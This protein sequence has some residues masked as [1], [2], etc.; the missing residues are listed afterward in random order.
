MTNFINFLTGREN[1]A[2]IDEAFNTDP[3]EI[4]FGKKN[5]GDIF[6]TFIDEEDKEYR[7]QFYTPA[8]LGKNVRQVFIGQKRG[9]T[10]PDAISRFKNP[11][12]VISTMIEAT[13]QFLL[14]PIGKGIDGF[15]INF[16]KK[17]LERGLT[18]LPKIIRQS[19]LKA[20]L[21][22]M[23]L[24]YSPDPSRGY[25]W[26]IRKGSDPAAVFDGPKMK[27]IT[28]D[29]PD[30]V[31]D[32]PSAQDIRDAALQGDMDD[33]SQAINRTTMTTKVSAKRG[34]YTGVD[35]DRMGVVINIL[36]NGTTPII[37][38]QSEDIAKLINSKDYALQVNIAIRQG[39]Q[40]FTD[41]RVIAQRQS[42]RFG[43]EFRILNNVDDR[44]IA[45]MVLLKKPGLK[46]PTD[47]KDVAGS[48]TQT[49]EWKLTTAG[50]KG[51]Q[52][53]LLWTNTAGRSTITADIA[54]HASEPGVYIGGIMNEK[55]M[56][57]QTP[58]SVARVLR[59]PQIPLHLLNEFTRLS[60][61]FWKEN[62]PKKNDTSVLPKEGTLRDAADHIARM[63][64]IV[65]TYAP[66]QVGMFS[67]EK[68]TR[69]ASG[70]Y[71]T[72][73]G[74]NIQIHF[75][76]ID[77]QGYM[78][79]AVTGDIGP[80][81]NLSLTGT[82]KGAAME[83][84]QAIAITVDR[85]FD[86]E[87]TVNS[88]PI[89]GAPYVI[90]G[91]SGSKGYSY[92]DCGSFT[93]KI[94]DALIN[95][96]KIG[97]AW[98]LDLQ[99]EF[100]R[101][102][103]PIRLNWYNKETLTVQMKDGSMIFG[104]IKTNANQK[105][106][107][108]TANIKRPANAKFFGEDVN[109]FSVSWKFS[110][111][112]GGNLWGAELTSNVTYY[113]DK[114]KASINTMLV[115]NGKVMNAARSYEVDLT[116]AS[117][118]HAIDETSQRLGDAERQVRLLDDEQYN[119]NGL[120]LNDV[121]VDSYGE[122]RFQDKALHQS[123]NRNVIINL[124]S[125]PQ[126]QSGKTGVDLAT[127]IAQ[128]DK[129]APKTSNVYWNFYAARDGQS[130]NVGWSITFRRNSRVGAMQQYAGEIRRANE[131]LGDLYHRAIAAGY[132][133]DK[134][135]LMTLQRAQSGDEMSERNGD[136]AYSEYEQ[137]IGGDMQIRIK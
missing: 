128:A 106:A 16:S 38:F 66:Q 75:M 52:P 78:V 18:L 29:D 100:P 62:D 120:Y 27:G 5:A 118:Q 71:R 1:K 39:E 41:T 127:F 53:M 61:S 129:E 47:T 13:K 3:Y 17:A 35:V 134:P 117:I 88:V 68:L 43:F 49:S 34:T 4:T 112:R 119:P 82:T 124:L 74:M 32:A 2:Q 50:P 79:V 98:E 136:G 22:V 90:N 104:D 10:Y 125:R 92:V 93:V 21:N 7:I 12:R 107:V 14:T 64:G 33:L 111:P 25:V 20:K 72:S 91:I 101:T 87:I 122:V 131:Y 123:A 105:D 115:Q 114:K 57:G 6:F 56:R 80:D 37:S 69:I 103:F 70:K 31:G 42:T 89:N 63:L 77:H 19:G 24:T 121:T 8:G 73:G 94:A 45:D 9:A 44:I 48:V 55:R 60:T 58:D 110:F 135:D 126:P 109:G 51:D 133:A 137:E 54:P 23:D 76:G 83:I 132:A 65:D 96:V 86:G 102:T 30:K 113:H 81:I 28:W 95:R 99:K 116:V 97:K 108:I 67:G 36:A 46:E 84:V 40:T 130:F 26:V 11:A 15:A 59:L 85:Q